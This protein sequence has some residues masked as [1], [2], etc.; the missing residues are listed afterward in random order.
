M[1]MNNSWYFYVFLCICCLNFHDIP[2]I[3]I[4]ITTSIHQS[5]ES[6]WFLVDDR[7]SHPRH[8]GDVMVIYSTWISSLGIPL[9]PIPSEARH[10]TRSFV[11]SPGRC[12]SSRKTASR[13]RL[14]TWKP[15]RSVSTKRQNGKAEIFGL[16]HTSPTW[17]LGNFGRN[18]T[19]DV[20]NSLK[21]YIIFLPVWLD[22]VWS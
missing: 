4:P 15:C 18:S 3:S 17:N 21:T 1:G 11:P 5:L 6:P 2:M 16:H 22:Q 9:I 19:W 8:Y 7:D 14:C 13:R 20:C 10:V 12:R